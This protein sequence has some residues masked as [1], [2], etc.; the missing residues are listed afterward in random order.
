MPCSRTVP[1][2]GRQRVP[3]NRQ[4]TGGLRCWVEGAHPC[5]T[6]RRSQALAQSGVFLPSPRGQQPGWKAPEPRSCPP[7]SRLYCP[8][9][10]ARRSRSRARG[11]GLAPRRAV[12]MAPGTPVS[13]QRPLARAPGPRPLPR[14]G[15]LRRDGASLQSRGQP[16]DHCSPSCDI[17]L[18]PS[19]CDP[20][21]SACPLLLVRIVEE[22][23]P[24]PSTLVDRTLRPS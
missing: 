1:D 10:A 2:G 13:P 11:T 15:S 8:P 14:C 24:Q 12:V 5:L 3:A 22:P 18:C 7:G 19:P 21:P 4:G 16:T 6:V 17:T 20:H 9:P 23:D